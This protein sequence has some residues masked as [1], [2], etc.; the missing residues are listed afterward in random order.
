MVLS[1][2]SLQRVIEAHCCTVYRLKDKAKEITPERRTNVFHVFRD[3]RYGLDI[4]T[5]AA[6]VYV[7]LNKCC[8]LFAGKM[9]RP[10][11]QELCWLAGV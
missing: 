11:T 9:L 4:C 3:C 8:E 1:A 5:T 7:A 2:S 10:A 6:C